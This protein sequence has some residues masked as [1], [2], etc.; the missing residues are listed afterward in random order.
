M[1]KKI[2]IGSRGSK[3]ALIYAQKAKDKIIQNTELNDEDIVIKE[4]TTKGDQVQDIRLSE[5]GGKGLFSKDIPAI[6]TDGLID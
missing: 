4:I 5:V 3:L 2:I 1:N 6:E